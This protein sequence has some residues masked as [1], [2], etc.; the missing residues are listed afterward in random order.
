M[1]PKYNGDFFSNK[2]ETILQGYTFAQT[3]L[4][5]FYAFIY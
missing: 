3:K 1:L 2:N 4:G 5:V